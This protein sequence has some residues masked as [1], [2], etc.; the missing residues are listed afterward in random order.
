MPIGASHFEII[1]VNQMAVNDD[2]PR[3]FFK[4]H[5]FTSFSSQKSAYRRMPRAGGSRHSIK[6]LEEATNVFKILFV[7]Q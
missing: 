6:W 5:G 3:A 4:T 7:T 2:S 1:D